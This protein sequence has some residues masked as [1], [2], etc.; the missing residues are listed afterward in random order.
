MDNQQ[1]F[2]LLSAYLDQELSPEEVEEVE[3]WLKQDKKARRTYHNLLQLRYRL[4]EIP[5]PSS[6]LPSE[7]LSHQVTRKAHTQRMRQWSLW[8]GSAIAALFVVILTSFFS[9]SHSPL[10]RLAQSDEK[11][12]SQDSLM[13][14]VDQPIMEI[15]TTAA[16]NN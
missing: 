8:G 13:I 2:E 6:Q 16:E 9:T 5:I 7:R 11:S 1:R 14:E 10:F 15:P 3:Q 4:R 12:L